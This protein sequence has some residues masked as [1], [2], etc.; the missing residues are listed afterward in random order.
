MLKRRRVS[1]E[2]E[3]DAD[4]NLEPSQTELFCENSLRSLAESKSSI[5]D[6]Y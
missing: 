3:L 4:R 5:L 1:T 2:N 6:V